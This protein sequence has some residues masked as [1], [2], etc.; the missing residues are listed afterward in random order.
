[1][2]VSPPPSTGVETARSGPDALRPPARIASATES[3]GVGDD[4]SVEERELVSSARVVT[5]VARVEAAIA[6][7]V[8]ARF[9]PEDDPGEGGRD[10]REGSPDG[11]HPDSSD[12]TAASREDG[13]SP[14]ETG[15]TS[16]APSPAALRV[17]LVAYG[18]HSGA[19]ARPSAPVLPGE[20]PAGED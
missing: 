7:R 8:G 12:D 10:R 13:T 5:A 15:P 17:A 6:A 14:A 20:R 11:E 2:I 19:D 18:K 4:L 1:M 9:E 16:T 3:P